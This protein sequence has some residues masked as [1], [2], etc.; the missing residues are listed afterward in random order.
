MLFPTLKGLPVNRETPIKKA[1]VQTIF[2]DVNNYMKDGVLL[3]QVLNVIDDIDFFDY[4]ESHAF[5][6]I[7]ESILKELQSTGSSGE[8][9]TLRAVTDF[10]AKMIEPII[11]E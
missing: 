7:Y 6:D 3:R 5:G 11:G 1:I 4:N 10:M 2:Q 8:F 9:Y